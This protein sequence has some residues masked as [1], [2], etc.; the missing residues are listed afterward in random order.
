MYRIICGLLVAL[1]R[2]S[3]C[4][5]RAKDLEIVALRRQLGVLSRQVN[6]P[7]MSS[8]AQAFQ[9]VTRSVQAKWSRPAQVSAFCALRSPLAV[10]IPARGPRQAPPNPTDVFLALSHRTC[11]ELDVC[12]ATCAT[13]RPLALPRTL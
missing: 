4:S 7:R 12:S 10:I 5:R 13:L 9:G 1:A 3:V 11:F 8:P 6:R 2:L